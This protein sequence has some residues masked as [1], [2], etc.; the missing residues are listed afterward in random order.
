[1]RLRRLIAAMLLA[2]PA[3]VP[4]MASAGPLKIVAAENFYGDLARQIG[5]ADVRVTSILSNPETDPHLFETSPSAARALSGADVIIYNGAG[6][7]A[8]MSRLLAAS[9]GPKRAIIDAAA[10]SGHSDSDNPHIWYDPAV[11]PA[12]ARDLAAMLARLDPAHAAAYGQNLG[13]F[14]ASVAPI[15]RRVADIR[16]RHAGTAVTATEPVF[17][18]MARALGFRMLN[19]G[20]Q[21]AAMNGTEPGPSQVAAF[22]DSLRDGSARILFY[23]SQV[24]NAATNRLLDIAQRNGVPVIGVT[25]T[26]PEGITIQT[27]FG[28][29]LDRIDS[30]LNGT[31][32]RP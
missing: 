16:S 11:L 17:G 13:K 32:A 28:R 7:D 8:W 6:Y 2:V 12:V 21:L 20:F 24:T 23:N 30:A 4:T 26:E 19:D 18:Y 25:E 14:L 15:E 27:W 29:L 10:L 22:E 5:G 1:M 9:S 31:S 3:S